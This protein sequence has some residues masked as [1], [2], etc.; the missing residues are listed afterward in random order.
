MLPV[1]LY[2]PQSVG[3]FQPLTDFLPLWELRAGAFT[4]RERWELFLRGRQVLFLPRPEIAEVASALA[5]N[6][7][8]I[9]ER[10]LPAEADFVCASVLPLMGFDLSA[11]VE[12]GNSQ[13]CRRRTRG[14]FLGYLTGQLTDEEIPAQNAKFMQ[15][16]RIWQL[17]EYLPTLL[18]NDFGQFRKSTGQTDQ[19]GVTFIG[20]PSQ[21]AI[22]QSAKLLPQT[23]VDTTSGPVIIDDEVESKPFSY[24]AGPLY[25][26][27]RS[28]LLGGKIGTSSFGSDCRVHG[29]VT[30]TVFCDC[31]NKAHYGFIGHSYVAPFVNFGA[32]ATNS[33]LKNTYGNIK[34]QTKAG[35]VD[36]GLGKFGFV[37][38]P[39]T[40]FGIGSL[41]ST[42]SLIGGFCNLFAGG[43]F[44]PKA[45]DHFSW[46]DGA[47]MASFRFDQA[48]H[49]A[50]RASERRHRA[51]SAA[52]TKRALAIYRKV[53][54]P[55]K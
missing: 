41:I 5:S 25:V 7:Q 22:S 18:A 11:F 39:H 27:K 48:A 10:D 21:R 26:G 1:V 55:P 23:V 35:T 15:L 28:I 31:V 6:I 12:D 42:G 17:V 50:Q 53:F 29:E 51:F 38:G 54:R 8:V 37:C 44:L 34:L 52:E 46:F 32:M 36:T 4:I 2:E 3:H 33:N 24:L 14:E 13:L 40:K 19:H 30:D 43:A 45:I 9:T 49:V 20:D 47:T 16:T